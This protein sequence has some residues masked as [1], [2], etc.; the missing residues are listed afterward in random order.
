MANIS[1][2]ARN[3]GATS[4]VTG[5]SASLVSPS[6]VKLKINPQDIVALNR[7]GNDLVITLNTGEKITIENYFVVDAQGHGNELVFEDEHGAL[8][9]VKDPQAGL[10]FDPL[11]DIDALMLDQSN[12]EGALPW[13]LGA[14]G[15]AAAGGIA[16]AAG[17]GGGGGHHD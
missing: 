9:W 7:T 12:H 6:I 16:L 17:G 1:I 15:I 13:V 4:T 5:E 2:T 14:L 10:H 11:A 8:W 3:G